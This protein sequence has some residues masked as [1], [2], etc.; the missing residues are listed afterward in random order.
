[1]YKIIQTM[2]ERWRKASINRRLEKTLKPDP[3]FR[4]RRLAQFDA[5]RREKYERNVEFLR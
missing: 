5:E 3:E 2:I 1:M 4:A